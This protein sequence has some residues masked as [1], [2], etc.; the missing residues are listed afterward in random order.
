M[1]GLRELNADIHFDMGAALNQWHPLIESRTGVFYHGIHLVSMDR[2]IIPEYKLFNVGVMQQPAEWADAD[3]EGAS[4]KYEVVPPWVE[5]Y[6]DMRA[7]AESCKDP[8][9]Q[10][11]QYGRVQKRWVVMDKKVRG[12]CIRVGW[13]HTFERL[14]NS[15]IPGI[16]RKSLSEK[17]GV[18]M[19]RFGCGTLDEATA[20]LVEE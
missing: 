9:L 19:F 17:F 8:G 14:V 1:K 18:D 2:G 5:G 7:I 6:H 11:D 12:R 16:T 10:L 3:K 13:R 15:N 20:A 4:I